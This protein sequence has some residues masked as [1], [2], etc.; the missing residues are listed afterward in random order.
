VSASDIFSEKFALEGLTFDDVLLVPGYSDLA[1]GE[2]RTRTRLSRGITVNIPLISAAM[3]TVTEARMAIA[4]ARQGGA[5]VLHRNLSVADQAAQVDMV[6]RSESGMITQPVTVGPDATLAEVDAL[7]AK[8]R[9]SGLPVV[10]EAGLLIG[11]VTNRDLRFETDHTRRVH[12]VMTK[13]PLVTGKVGTTGDEAMKLMGAHKIEKLPLVDDEGR[14]HGL[15]TVKDF[16]KSD[17]YPNATKDAEGRLVV[18]AAVGVGDDA[19]RRAMALVE[20]GADFI[21]S[22][23]AHGHTGALAETVAKIKANAQVDVI[24]G[25]VVTAAGAQALIDAGADAVKVGVGPGSICTTR[26]VAGVGMP[27]ITA[28]YEVA[29]AARPAGVPVIGDGGLQYSGDIAKAI[30][31]GADTVMLGSLLAGCEESPGELIFINGKQY[32]QYRGM[33]SLSA[34]SSRGKPEGKSYSR[35]RYAQHEV[36]SDD[37]LIPEGVEGQVPFRG[38]VAAVAHQLIGGVGQAMHYTGSRTIADLQR[39]QF[40]RI[41]SAGLTESHPHDIQMTVEAPNYHSR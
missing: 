8:Y 37:K 28:I 29:K 10:D 22:D 6:K 21:V 32:K 5:G 1:P 24:A 34:M 16:T 2:A 27:Q 40:V 39:A 17:Q 14:L 36:S 7:C 35:D 38:P 12:E 31:A 3:D 23:V 41:T 13:A 25:N 20:A 4:M 19:F 33:G 15:I 11:I 30:A 26:V 9:I 18:G